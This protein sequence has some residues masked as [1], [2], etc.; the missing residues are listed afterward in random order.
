M[1]EWIFCPNYLIIFCSET[2]WV[3]YLDTL[4]MNVLELLF[5]LTV[6]IFK[7]AAFAFRPIFISSL[8]LYLQF[9][10]NGH[11]SVVYFL[12]LSRW[13]LLLPETLGLS[14]SS[15]FCVTQWMA[16]QLAIEL[17]SYIHFFF[18]HCRD[19]SAVICHLKL[20]RNRRSSD[21]LSKMTSCFFSLDACRFSSL[22]LKISEFSKKCLSPFYRC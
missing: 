5:T 2:D 12:T 1:L 4:W 15:S 13:M 19:F 3:K 14:N 9:Y 16:C 10:W 6:F 8:V 22:N 17:L 21:F 11:F 7:N 18:I 20:L